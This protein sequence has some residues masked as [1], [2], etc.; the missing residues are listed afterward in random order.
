MKIPH[1]SGLWRAGKWHKL[2]AEADALELA[3]RAAFDGVAVSLLEIVVAKVLISGVIAEQMV[4][5]HQQGVSN[6]HHGPLA[7][8]PCGQAMEQRPQIAR[9]GPRGGPGGLAQGTPQPGTALARSR[10]LALAATLAIAG[11]HP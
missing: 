2:D 3:Q 10:R 8:P 1:R 4:D 5:D 9:L 6:R 7:T 11:A